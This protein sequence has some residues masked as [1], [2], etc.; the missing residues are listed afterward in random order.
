MTDTNTPT[1]D[2]P[3][4]QYDAIVNWPRR[5][6]RETPFYRRWFETADVRR[7][8]DAACGTGRHAAMFHSWGLT[9][10]GADLSPEMIAHCR[11]AHGEDATLQWAIRSFSEPVPQAPFD[12]VVCV[13]N[14]LAVLPDRSALSGAVGCLA[15]AVRPGGVLIAHLLNIWSIPEGPICWQKCQALTDHETDA[16][17]ILLKGVHRVNDR[18]FI[19]MLK[20]R[21]TGEN[22]ERQERNAELLGPRGDELVAIA[23]DAGLTSAQ[24]FGGYRDEPYDPGNSTDLILVARRSE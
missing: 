1:F 22:V 16:G 19:S 13:G 9:V 10:E 17:A 8:L 23:G 3:P 4:A 14:S 12:A 24:L 21:Q 18:A 7:V 15:D 5:L 2:L 11:A 20:L 6:A